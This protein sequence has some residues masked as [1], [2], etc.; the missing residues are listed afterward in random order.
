MVGSVAYGVAQDTSDRDVYGFCIPP[1]DVVFPHLA[2][3]I[4]GFGTHRRRFDQYQQHHIQDVDAAG[5]SGVEYDVVIYSIVR[6]FQ[7]CGL[8]QDWWTVNLLMS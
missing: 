7:L 6:Y 5:G 4:M 2:G 3:E 1:K 8:T